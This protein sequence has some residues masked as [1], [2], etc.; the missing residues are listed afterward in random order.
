MAIIR[1]MIDDGT[2]AIAWPEVPDRTRLH[3]LNRAAAAALIIDGCA[4]RAYF[5]IPRRDN[6]KMGHCERRSCS[7]WPHRHRRNPNRSLLLA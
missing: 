3:D 5:G 1:E 6:R 2:G 4:A 7:T